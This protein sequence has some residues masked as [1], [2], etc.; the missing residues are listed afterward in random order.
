MLVTLVMQVLPLPYLMKM[1]QEQI[2]QF[3]GK[4]SLNSAAETLH[5]QRSSKMSNMQV[6]LLV[7]QLERP[8]DSWEA[9]VLVGFLYLCE[10]YHSNEQLVIF[11][12]Y[13]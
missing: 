7:R 5:S 2:K 6:S 8:S 4:F 1:C 11:V 12:V 3:K 10:S 9:E 13:N